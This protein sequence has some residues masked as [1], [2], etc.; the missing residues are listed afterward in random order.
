MWDLASSQC[1][2]TIGNAHTNAI[3]AFL[4]WESALLSSALDGT[5]KCWQ[6]LAPPAPGAVLKP[7]PDHVF[8]QHAVQQHRVRH[9][10]NCYVA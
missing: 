2:Q 5:I 1:T 6:A 7:T 3:T 9:S 10:C 8:D 4:I